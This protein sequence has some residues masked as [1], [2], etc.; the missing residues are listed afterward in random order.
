MY[1]TKHYYE[2]IICNT[3]KRHYLN[4]FTVYKDPLQPSLNLINKTTSLIQIEERTGLKFNVEGD[5]LTQVDFDEMNKERDW[6]YNE[7]VKE[8]KEEE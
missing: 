1:R 3:N 8:K 6:N 7:V 5:S 4:G 2:I